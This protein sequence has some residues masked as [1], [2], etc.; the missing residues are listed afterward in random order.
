[1][2]PTPQVPKVLI[3]VVAPLGQDGIMS[4]IAKHITKGPWRI[5]PDSIDG[6]AQGDRKHRC[7]A[8]AQGRFESRRTVRGPGKSLP[9]PSIVAVAGTNQEHEGRPPTG[10][11][12]C[13]R[14]SS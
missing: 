7:A 4:G 12:T 5:T 13:Y 8:P 6:A 10:P 2:W 9:L 3:G 11:Q 1:M 14:P